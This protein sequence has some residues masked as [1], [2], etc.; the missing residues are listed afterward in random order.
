MAL[1]AGMSIASLWM[2]SVRST[3]QISG[4]AS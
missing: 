2:K 3:V 1:S 4:H